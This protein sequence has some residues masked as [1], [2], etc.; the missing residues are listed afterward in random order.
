MRVSLILLACVSCV[1]AFPAY[2]FPYGNS[3]EVS[4]VRRVLD[5][6][7]LLYGSYESYKCRSRRERRPQQGHPQLTVLE[8]VE[9]ES[10][11]IS[12]HEDEHAGT[13]AIRVPHQAKLVT[14]KCKPHEIYVGELDICVEAEE[15][16]VRPKVTDSKRGQEKQ[17]EDKK[18]PV[19]VLEV[20]EYEKKKCGPGEIWVPEVDAC[21]DRN[22]P[23][24][25]E[26]EDS[27]PKS[28]RLKKHGY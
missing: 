8:I 10:G 14:P 28:Q 16:L 24:P 1:V 12:V 27:P 2:F 13:F 25:L 19:R 21:L 7:E 15:H 6:P 11:R 23:P 4:W 22:P 3:Q 26:P 18:E 5:C 20:G 9:P 17:K